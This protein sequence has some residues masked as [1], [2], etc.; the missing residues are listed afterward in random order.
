MENN[1]INKVVVFKIIISLIIIMLVSLPWYKFNISWPS[2]MF[3]GKVLLELN[4]IIALVFLMIYISINIFSKK[5]RLSNITNTVLIDVLL[6]SFAYNH[7][8]SVMIPI[9]VVFK[10]IYITNI[11]TN[12]TKINNISDI[13]MYIGFAFV[14]IGNIPFELLNLAIDQGI[15]II[16]ACIGLYDGI[17]VLLSEKK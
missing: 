5:S 3:G 8:I 17:D 13:L 7:N 16:A 15:I 11:R 9:I 12:K 2:Y 6:I 14:L 4:Y 1:K 10:D